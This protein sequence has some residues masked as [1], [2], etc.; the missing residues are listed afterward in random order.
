[1]QGIHCTSDGAVGAGRVSASGAAEQGAYV[2]RSLIDAGAAVSNGTDAPVEDVDPIPNFH[3]LV[4]RRTPGTESRSIPEQRMTRMEAL[5]AYT[6]NAAYAAFEEGI[7]GS[8]DAG[9]AG[10]RDRAVAG[11]PDRARGADPRGRGGPHDRRR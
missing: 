6:I 8:L 10:R 4:T 3:A 11:H 9:Q 7:K 1:M 5:R 2:W